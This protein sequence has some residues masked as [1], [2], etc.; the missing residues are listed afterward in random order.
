MQTLRHRWLPVGPQHA[1]PLGGFELTLLV[2]RAD[3]EG[4]WHH[5]RWA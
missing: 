3:T 1:E 4:C 5:V 2:M